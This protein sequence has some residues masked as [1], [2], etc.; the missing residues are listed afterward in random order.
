MKPRQPRLGGRHRAVPL[1]GCSLPAL[2]SSPP[3]P[4][5]AE[6][7]SFLAFAR[8]LIFSYLD[9]PS[10]NERPRDKEQQ[11]K[12][13][14]RERLADILARSPFRSQHLPLCGAKTHP[15][16]NDRVAL[17]N[18][19]RHMQI[20]PNHR[21]TSRTLRAWWLWF[22]GSKNTRPTAPRGHVPCGPAKG[23]LDYQWEEDVPQQVDEAPWGEGIDSP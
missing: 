18:C 16:K 23:L 6:N 8:W 2:H 13:L 4:S 22:K 21:E 20:K 12:V 9:C 3:P 17:P 14:G 10:A 7:T 5:P 11:V 1:R 15:R 19:F